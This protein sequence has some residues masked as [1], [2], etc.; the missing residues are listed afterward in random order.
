MDNKQFLHKPLLT[1]FVL[2]ISSIN[3]LLLNSSLA[4]SSCDTKIPTFW[5]NNNSNLL[6]VPK[7]INPLSPESNWKTYIFSLQYQY[8]IKT[9]GYKN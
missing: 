7:R 6:K 4:A 8:L 3:F 5:T 2:L 9:K 1:V